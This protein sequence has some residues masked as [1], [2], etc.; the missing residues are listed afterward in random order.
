MKISVVTV[1]YNCVS[2]IADCLF[3]VETQSHGIYDAT[4][5]GI[6]LAQ[7]D[8][9][10]FLNSDDFFADTGV[11]ARVASLFAD[12]PRLDACYADLIYVDQKT[13]SR[14]VRHWK[15]SNFSL[16][17]FAKGWC[18]A[19]PTFFVRRSVYERFCSLPRQVDSEDVEFSACCLNNL[20][21]NFPSARWGRSSL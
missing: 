19:H 2:F 20:G 5:K 16:G 21:G 18:P 4:N 14:T 10:G 13:T 9:I 7:G 1:S 15:S 12:D 17:A 8:V 6:N 11:L 3:S